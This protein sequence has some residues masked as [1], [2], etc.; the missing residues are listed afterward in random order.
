MKNEREHF[1][2]EENCRA[3]HDRDRWHCTVPGCCNHDIQVAHRIQK[4]KVFG[5]LEIWNNTYN[6]NRNYHWIKYNVIHHPLNVTTSCA[7]HNSSFNIGNN[8]GAVREKLEE[9][10]ENLINTGV[11][12]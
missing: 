8:P 11:I 4:Y 2:I 3:I 10:R 7:F 6:E 5:V 1:E 12:K 9:I